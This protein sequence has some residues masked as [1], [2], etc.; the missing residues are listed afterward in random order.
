MTIDGARPTAAD[1]SHSA[2]GA[3]PD[4][5][6]YRMLFEQNPHPMWI[7]DLETLQILA[8]NDA[9]IAHYGYTR[10]E[11]LA[12]TIMDLRPPEDVPRLLDT[13]RRIPDGISKSG[14]WRHRKAN[15]E[16][17]RVEISS[18]TMPFGNRTA[19]MVLAMDVTARL[20]AEESLRQSESFLEM[21]SKLGRLGAWSV[22]LPSGEHRWSE[23]ARE[24]HGVDPGEKPHVEALFDFYP[25]PG[26]T[27]LRRAFDRCATDGVAFDLEIP[28]VTAKGRSTWVRALGVAVRDEAGRIVRVQGALQDVSD[29]KA[30]EQAL[31]QSEAAHRRLA[32]ENAHLARQLSSTLESITEAFYTMDREGRVTYLN[33]RANR[34]FVVPREEVLG[35]VPWEVFPPLMET[36]VYAAIQ[37]ALA[38]GV[39]TAVDDFA[40]T[41][42]RWFEARVYASAE[43]IG[44]SFN[45]VT[46]RHHAREALRASEERF[47]LLSRATNDAIWDWDLATDQIWWNEGYEKILGFPHAEVS[48]IDASWTEH[49]HPEDR[50]R[51]VGGIRAVIEGGGTEWSDEYRF[52]HRDGRDVHVSDRGQVLRDASGR[53]VRMIGGMTDRT[54]QKRAEERLRELATLLDKAQDAIVVRDLEQRILYWNRGAERLYGWTT[55]EAVGRKITELVY[56]DITAFQSAVVANLTHG[57]WMGELEQ[58]T[59]DGRTITVESRWTL[60]RDAHGRPTSTLTINTDVSE[61]KRLE[62]QFLRAQRM[63]SVGT[64]AGGIAHDLNNVLAPILMSVSMLRDGEEDPSRLEDLASIEGCA[65]RGADMIRQ[66]LSFARGVDGRRVKLDLARIAQEVQRIVRDTFPKNITFRLTVPPALWEVE[67][68]GTQMHQLLTNLCVNARDAMPQGGTLRVTLGH[69]VLDEVYAGM[70]VDSRPGPYVVLEVEDT[71][72]GMPPDVVDRI[73]EPFFTTKPVGKGTGLGLSTVHAIVRSHHGFIHVYSEVGKGTRFKIYLPADAPEGAADIALAEQAMVPR[74]NGELVLVVDDEEPI[75]SVAKRTLERFGYRVLLAAHGAEAVSLYAQH[76]GE[77]AVVL[78]DMTMPVMDGPATI[79]ALRSMDPRVR[80][81]GS[82][83]LDANGNVAK[84]VDA[85]I[86]LFVPKPYTAET[87]LRMLRKVLQDPQP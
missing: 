9:A 36:P 63:E 49:L 19:R 25:E 62:Q 81:I 60:V 32:E 29:R 33:E 87:L 18:L 71:G 2:A 56:R 51:V 14:T 28:F 41:S 8:V 83:G 86:Q 6:L 31:V 10:S 78:T 59:K 12:R 16:L 40:T 58:V 70:N 30:Q 52:I 3:L 42:G 47:R 65:Q 20:A 61:K 44:V 43:G 73:F 85:G 75:R 37:R 11:F 82:S 46:E 27:E 35:R 68:D 57:E 79:V 77:I 74:G 54:E 22:E 76:K 24:L 84:A 55:A 38:E 48:P 69:V 7:Y 66:L 15:G 53:A 26:R 13:V 64:L 39:S 80:I 5:A 72:T 1:A 17:I 4:D 67:A 23:A 34:A 21:A 45:E 50:A